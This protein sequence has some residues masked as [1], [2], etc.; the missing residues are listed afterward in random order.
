MGFVHRGLQDFNQ[1]GSDG[2]RPDA[3]V[4]PITVAGEIQ[5]V[6]VSWADVDEFD[7]VRGGWLAGE[8]EVAKRKQPAR[9]VFDTCSDDDELYVVKTGEQNWLER[10]GTE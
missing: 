2:L 5:D 6:W 1:R 4:L 7:G 10:G 9:L 8:G 3:V